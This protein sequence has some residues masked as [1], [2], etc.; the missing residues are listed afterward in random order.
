MVFQYGFNPCL[1]E[2]TANDITLIHYM[3]K[4]LYKPFGISSLPFL[5]SVLYLAIQNLA[6]K[7]LV[8]N[9]QTVKISQN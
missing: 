4:H 8:D 3:L 5:R 1:T 2:A 7:I 6:I 9:Y